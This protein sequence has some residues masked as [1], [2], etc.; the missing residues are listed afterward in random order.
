M[1]SGGFYLFNLHD[2]LQSLNHLCV[3]DTTFCNTGH[4]MELRVMH[5]I[6]RIK[7][8]TIFDSRYPSLPSP[9]FELLPAKSILLEFEWRLYRP[10][11]HGWIFSPILYIKISN[12]FHQNFMKQDK[13]YHSIFLGW[14]PLPILMQSEYLLFVFAIVFP[15]PPNI[16]F[17]ALLQI[18]LAYQ[19]VSYPPFHKIKNRNSSPSKTFYLPSYAM[20]SL[21]VS[22]TKSKKCI[23][24]WRFFTPI[25]INFKEMK[26]HH[27][28]VSIFL[29]LRSSPSS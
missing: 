14:Q 13:F 16:I 22:F 24:I 19:T 20:I 25:L 28:S 29:T 17:M 12:K 27:Q 4:T 3:L 6:P 18:W 1:A 23:T 5:Y 2:S 26:W 9:G 11:H 21:L 15:L 8:G 10:S 7:R